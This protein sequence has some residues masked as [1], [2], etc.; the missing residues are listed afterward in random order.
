MSVNVCTQKNWKAVGKNV[1]I[2]TPRPHRTLWAGSR[3]PGQ[4]FPFPPVK[5]DS[6]FVVVVLFTMTMHAI[7]LK[8]NQLF[9][10]L[11]RHL[12]YKEGDGH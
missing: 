5:S 10:F 8:K 1:N 9:P 3:L 6:I 7:V 11:K 4:F 12:F 2:T